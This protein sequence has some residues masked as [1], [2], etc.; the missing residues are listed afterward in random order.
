MALQI[1]NTLE[2]QEGFQITNA[3][4][5]VAVV[6]QYKGDYLQGAVEIYKDEAA[7]LAGQNPISFP[8][9]L[10]GVQFDYVYEPNTVNIL[11]LAHDE[12]ILK[13]EEQKIV[14]VKML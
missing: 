10:L 7:F 2:A 14:A 5:R 11:D 13:L 9:L 1:T 6:N 4:G 3:Y 12:V 8:D